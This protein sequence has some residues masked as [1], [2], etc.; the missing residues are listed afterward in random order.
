MLGVLSFRHTFIVY[1]DDIEDPFNT[2][3]WNEADP[4]LSAFVEASIK[5]G[6][7]NEPGEYVIWFVDV[8]ETEQLLQIAKLTVE[9]TTELNML[10]YNSGLVTQLSTRENSS[11]ERR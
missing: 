9:T 7:I 11:T 6:A 2:P 5:K 10:T 8:T 1:I 3:A 4:V